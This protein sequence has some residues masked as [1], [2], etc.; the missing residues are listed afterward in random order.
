MDFTNDACMNLFTQGQ[1][2]RMRS[3]FGSGSLRRSLLA[4]PG[5]SAP[6][7]EEAPVVSVP[8]PSNPVVVAPPAEAPVA[9]P[10]KATFFPNP[11]NQWLQVVL[12]DAS[13]LGKE[14]QLAGMNGTVV[15]KVT[16]TTLQQKINLQGLSDGLYLV[17]GQNGNSMLTEKIVKLSS[18]Q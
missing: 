6:T 16:I 5:L 4:S 10:K 8:A 13:W 12:P 7:V 9:A 15:R 17:R 1:K 14:L 18:G 2:A 11:A 3:L